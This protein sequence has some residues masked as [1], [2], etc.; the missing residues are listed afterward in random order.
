[1]TGVDTTGATTGINVLSSEASYDIVIVIN[2]LFP[3]EK[4]KLELSTYSPSKNLAKEMGKKN[5]R[6]KAT[7]KP[8]M[9]AN[10]NNDVVDRQGRVA[11]EI[12]LSD[13]LETLL[14]LGD[15]AVP[16]RRRS[17]DL[18]CHHTA[19]AGQQHVNPST[20]VTNFMKALDMTSN[21]IKKEMSPTNCSGF[22]LQTVWHE[23]LDTFPRSLIP[24]DKKSADDLVSHLVSY[25]TELILNDKQHIASGNYLT[26]GVDVVATNSRIY[27]AISHGIVAWTVLLVEQVSGK[28]SVLDYHSKMRDLL[29][30]IT[31][32][33]ITKFFHTRNTCNCLEKEYKR[34]RRNTACVCYQCLKVIDCK[35]ILQCSRCKVAQY[36]DAECQRLHW[37]SQHKEWCNKHWSKHKEWHKK[38]GAVGS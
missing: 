28:I 7:L 17:E 12:L 25:G 5:K 15:D 27:S 11:E 31:G 16:H 38:Q 19:R 14:Q 22:S 37:L 4:F 1:V 36:C 24:R 3:P 34:L 32:R 10:A 29:V 30:D 26:F 2:L 21:H 23:M 6:R 8:M 20:T 35:Q 9:A 13:Q 33:E 18:G